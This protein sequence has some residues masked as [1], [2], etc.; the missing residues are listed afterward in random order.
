MSSSSAVAAEAAAQQ[1]A[2]SQS[3]YGAAGNV[4]TLDGAW[5]RASPSASQV[6]IRVL[7]AGMNPADFRI[8]EGSFSGFFGLSFPH[9]PGFDCCGLVVECGAAVTRLRCGDAVYACCPFQT[10]GAFQQYLAVDESLVSLKPANMT[11][12]ETAAL[13]VASSTA[14]TALEQAGVT[15][16]SRVL[17]IGAS[18]G[19]GTYAVQI[20]KAMGAAYIAAVTST[21]NVGLVTGLGADVVIDYTQKSIKD[22]GLRDMDFIFDTVGG[23]W[24]ECASLLNE[25]GKF[26]ST[27]FWEAP[28][29]SAQYSAFVLSPSH[30][31]LDRIRALVEQKAVRSVIDC[32]FPFTAQGVH[33]MYAYC[34]KGRTRG[35]A[36][37]IVD[38]SHTD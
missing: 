2:V 10:A 17:I 29:A 3:A 7:A 4:L 6:V 32:Q 38:P 35:K 36:V 30:T 11:F 5:P 25:K 16:G 15:S 1:V 12:V 14:L 21:N 37:L 28:P 33:S 9:V 18:G 34:K 27:A 22:S 20:A 23:H 26:I 24:E 31:L 8:V 19:C 13:P